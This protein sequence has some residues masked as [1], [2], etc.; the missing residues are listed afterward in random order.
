MADTINDFQ[1]FIIP[2][3]EKT[4]FNVQKTIDN[5]LNIVKHNMKYNYINISIKND[6]NINLNIYGYENEFM[7]AVLNILNNAKEALLHN[8][9]KDRKLSILLKNKYNTLVIDIIDNGPGVKNINKDKI[10]KQYFST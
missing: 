8:T 3:K 6:K 1:D 10:F 5:M 7:Q 9:E 4:I 2:S